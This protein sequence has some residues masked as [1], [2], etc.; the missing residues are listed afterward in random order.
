MAHKVTLLKSWTNN[1]GRKYPIGQV[2]LCTK[3]LKQ[4]LLY[5]G[6]AKEFEG[7]YPPKKKVKTDFFKN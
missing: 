6:Y 3:E 7:T 5:G 1:S 2:I 4:E